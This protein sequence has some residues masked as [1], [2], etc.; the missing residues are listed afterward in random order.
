MERL[1]GLAVHRSSSDVFAMAGWDLDDVVTRPLR[2]GV[3]TAASVFLCHGAF[4]SSIRRIRPTTDARETRRALWG[5]PL[6]R[7]WP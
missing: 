1:G 2:I 6:S 5:S 7:K 3:D 4:P